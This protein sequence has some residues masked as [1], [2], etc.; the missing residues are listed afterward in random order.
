MRGRFFEN[1]VAEVMA[2]CGET[3]TLAVRRCLANSCMLSSDVTSAFDPVY[4]SV[5]EKKNA[6]F[7]GQGFALTKFTGARG[8]SGSNDANAEYIAL[9]RN[10][11]DKHGVVY[12]SFFRPRS[13]G[14]SMPAAAGRS[15]ISSPATE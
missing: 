2:L 7:L 3:G 5:F 6:A 14:A 1:C 4:A 13:W 10:I 9:L 8:K 12:L 11:L 15:P